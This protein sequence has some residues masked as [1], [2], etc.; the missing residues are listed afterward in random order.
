MSGFVRPDNKEQ[1]TEPLT[2]VRAVQSR[3]AIRK[4]EIVER[5][6]DSAPFHF[7]YEPRA[8]SRATSVIAD[9]DTRQVA[10]LT[11]NDRR[12]VG[13][14]ACVTRRLDHCKGERERAWDSLAS[15]TSGLIKR[16]RKI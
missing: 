10:V 15:R 13:L 14:R 3:R 8:Q 7:L 6:V 4:R 1:D 2:A 5:Q 9:L 12:L 11:G 16:R